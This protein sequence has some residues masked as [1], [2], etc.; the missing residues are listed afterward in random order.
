MQAICPRVW[1]V[2]GP[3]PGHPWHLAKPW[4]RLFLPDW[5]PASTAVCLCRF[6]RVSPCSVFALQ[7]LWRLLKWQSLS[8]L[9]CAIGTVASQQAPAVGS[10]APFGAFLFICIRDNESVSVCECVRVCASVWVRDAVAG[11]PCAY[12]CTHAARPSC[13]RVAC[14]LDGWLAHRPRHRL[15]VSRSAFMCDPGGRCGAPT[16]SLQPSCTGSRSCR[17]YIAAAGCTAELLRVYWP[18]ADGRW[19]AW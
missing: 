15:F 1:Y 12:A 2:G 4:S 14:A 17:I 16:V 5:A 13:L 19:S 10:V 11:G 7:P 6:L 18:P 3:L 9:S 8:F